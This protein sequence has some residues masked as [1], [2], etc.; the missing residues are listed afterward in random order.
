M[1]ILFASING[2]PAVNSD[3]FVDI[4]GLTIELPPASP[5]AQHA[6]VV[7]NVPKP[8][9]IGDDF[10]GADFAIEV[11]TQVV[12][13][14]GFTYIQKAPP[15]AARQPITLVVR[16]ALTGAAQTVKGQ[17]QSVRKSTAHIDSF[18][19]LSAVLG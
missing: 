4:P 2:A 15:S 11:G 18:A 14:G 1:S 7:L 16:V 9:S 19:S 10:P 13:S 17:W 3:Q 6:L 5:T 8:F 12:A